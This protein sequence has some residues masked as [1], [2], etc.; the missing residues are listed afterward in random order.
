[1]KNN[2]LEE[3]KKSLIRC[4]YSRRTQK[5]YTHQVNNFLNFLGNENPA[6]LS[7]KTIDDYLYLCTKDKGYSLSTIKQIVGAINLFFREVLKKE[8]N[9]FYGKNIR[10]THYLPAV[11]SSEE[12]Q[13]LFKVCKNIKHKTV[14]VTIYSLGL[15]LSEVVSLKI[16]DIDSDRMEINIRQAKGNRDRIVF[17]PKNLLKLLR[18]YF[19]KYKPKEF[20]FEGQKGGK[21]SSTSVQKVMKKCLNLAEITKKASVHTLRHSFATHLLEQGTDIRFI[22]ELLGHKNI[23]TTQLYTKISKNSIKKIKS[24]IENI[25]I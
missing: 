19:L 17:L 7:K 3:F 8:L 5:I 24:P 23:S 13:K 9:Y 10:Q 20:L 16:S 2:Y 1:M 14:L 6:K 11:L 22:Q 18:E 25:D 15:R 4:R 12:V 21:Y